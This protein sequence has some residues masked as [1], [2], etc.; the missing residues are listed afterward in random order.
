MDLR[1]L[2]YRTLAEPLSDEQYRGE[3][4]ERNARAGG[5]V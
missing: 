3:I 2:T 4:R 1:P 5:P